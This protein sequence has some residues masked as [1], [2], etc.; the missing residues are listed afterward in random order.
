MTTTYRAYGPKGKSYLSK[1]TA[2]QYT[3]KPKDGS[4]QSGVIWNALQA[5]AALPDG[6]RRKKAVDMLV[7]AYGAQRD[8]EA[9]KRDK[10]TKAYLENETKRQIRTHNRDRSK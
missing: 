6:P 2:Q 8:V 5:A 9:V 3:R 10:E 1:E 4:S 7:R